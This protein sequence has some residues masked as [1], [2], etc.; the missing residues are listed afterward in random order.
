MLTLHALY[1]KYRDCTISLCVSKKELF[2]SV[3]ESGRI[4][5]QFF[6][7]SADKYHNPYHCSFTTKKLYTTER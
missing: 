7:W 3:N 5:N 2:V 4:K 6:S 1:G